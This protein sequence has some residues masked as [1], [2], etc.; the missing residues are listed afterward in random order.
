MVLHQG[1]VIGEGPFEA[2]ERNELVRDVY[3]GRQ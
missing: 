2:I 3:L 1:R